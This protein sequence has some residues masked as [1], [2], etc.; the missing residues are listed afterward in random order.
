MSNSA[1]SGIYG[2]REGERKADIQQ[3]RECYNP[4]VGPSI[5]VKLPAHIQMIFNCSLMDRVLR[6][7][8]VADVF[9]H[10]ET[11]R[12]PQICFI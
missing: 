6:S 3:Q 12:H 11:L 10:C 7:C 1:R 9:F 5:R 8:G 2:L 4:D